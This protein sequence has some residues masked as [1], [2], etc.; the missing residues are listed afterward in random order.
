[1]WWVENLPLVFVG[2]VDDVQHLYIILAYFVVVV[3]E[4]EN[5]IH[6]LS[7]VPSSENKT[8]PISIMESDLVSLKVITKICDSAQSPRL[9]CEKYFRKR[10]GAAKMR[11][12]VLKMCVTCK[13]KCDR[14]VCEWW[15]AECA[16]LRFQSWNYQFRIQVT[17]RTQVCYKN[18]LSNAPS[19]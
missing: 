14:N 12:T 19:P 9:V 13:Q 3:Y 1:M 16:L 5:S 10:K 2:V 15:I 17:C 11:M 4:L 7:V 6:W 8:L 18:A